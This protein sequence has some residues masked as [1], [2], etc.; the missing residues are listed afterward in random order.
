DIE[1]LNQRALEG[2]YEL[3]A[4]SFH[5]YPHV[6]SRY[7]PLDVGASFG[8]GYGPVLVARSAIPESERDAL[9]VAVPGRWTTA[10]LALRLALPG[11]KVVFRPFDRIQDEVREGKFRAGVLIHEGQLTFGELGLVKVLDLGEWWKT[12]T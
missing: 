5:A 6:A 7:A 11:V 1:T 12:E 9:E 10:H 2:T 3:T 4:I 8:D